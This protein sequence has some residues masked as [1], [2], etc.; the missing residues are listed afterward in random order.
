M[1]RKVKRFFG[2]FWVK[3]KISRNLHFDKFPDGAVK[4]IETEIHFELPEG[5]VFCRLANVLKLS[6]GKSIKVR[7]LTD[8]EIKLN[9]QD[10]FFSGT[11]WQAI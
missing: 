7:Q 11:H 10:H 2:R 1:Q 8:N 3:A 4:C 6:S 9:V 5:W